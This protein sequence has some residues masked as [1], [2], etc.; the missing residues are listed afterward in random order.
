MT[1][2]RHI[3]VKKDCCQVVTTITAYNKTLR[4]DP[5][6]IAGAH[7]KLMHINKSFQPPAKPFYFGIVLE[8]TNPFS[9]KR[10]ESSEDGGVIIY[11][12]PA[13]KSPYTITAEKPGTQFTTSQFIC[14]S[15]ALINLSP[16]HGPTELRT[17][18][19]S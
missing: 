19:H 18:Q 11:N 2:Q 6:G 7:V 14:R 8:K 16:P 10:T 9:S 3:H 1:K 13:S 12:L 17:P 15:G 4:D 5:Q